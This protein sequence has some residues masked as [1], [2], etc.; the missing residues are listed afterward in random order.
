MRRWWP[1]I[2]SIVVSVTLSSVLARAAFVSPGNPTSVPSGASVLVSSGTC[3]TGFVEDTAF[4]GRYLVGTPSGGTVGGTLGSAMTDLADSSY[5]PLGSG[6][7][8]TV[9]GGAA[10]ASNGVGML[11]GT[12]QTLTG[13][14]TTGAS[15][16]A[17]TFTGTAATTM[18][19]TVAPTAQL[20]V[21]RKS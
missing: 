4:R 18:R 21:C 9:S 10:A 14:G 15:V 6:T 3:P 17:V 8:A 19:S 5:T 2:V 11:G 12:L 1:H 7:I 16:G 20:L 13:A